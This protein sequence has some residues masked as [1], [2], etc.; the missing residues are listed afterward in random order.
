M[1]NRTEPTE[2][3]VRA[4]Q[5]W[6]GRM[7]ERYSRELCQRA[8]MSYLHRQVHLA[9]EECDALAR[10][11]QTKNPSYILRL[12]AQECG[13][14]YECHRTLEGMREHVEAWLIKHTKQDSTESGL[15]TEKA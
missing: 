4:H 11:R 14:A 15:F 9:K 3:E 13:T 10:C 2:Q 1:R 8:T 5:F 7:D 6:W 12:E